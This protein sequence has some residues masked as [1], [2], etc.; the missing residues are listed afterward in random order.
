MKRS[1]LLACLVGLAL[2]IPGIASADDDASTE[3][4]REQPQEQPEERWYGW[5]T[6][7]TDG[8]S[9]TLGTAGLGVAAASVGPFTP[10]LDLNGNGCSSGG[11]GGS[12][13]GMIAAASLGISASA[14][15]LLGAPIVHA[16]HGHWDK[17]GISLGLRSLPIAFATPLLASGSDDAQRVGVGVLVA[18]A[19]AAMAIDAAVIAREDVSPAPREKPRLGVAPN[20]DAVNRGG[21][22][23]LVGTF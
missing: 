1:H 3:Q 12:D 22:V 11:R 19:A 2:S 14:T 23:S 21:G 18:G 10:C 15:Y 7:T 5:Q 8:I 13:G 9:L 4:P 6:I 20:I 16:A 17:A